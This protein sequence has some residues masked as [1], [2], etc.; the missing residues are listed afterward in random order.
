MV[1]GV[2]LHKKLHCL[3]TKL[4]GI[5][6]NEI[7]SQVVY[8]SALLPVVLYA[9]TRQKPTLPPTSGREDSPGLIAAQS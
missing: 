5:T 3:H 2:Y 6:W 9:S 1:I 8:A 7:K 4:L